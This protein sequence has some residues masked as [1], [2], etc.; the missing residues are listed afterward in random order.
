LRFTQKSQFS[1]LTSLQVK[2]IVIQRPR[3]EVCL[4][5]PEKNS[6]LSH[7]RG[8]EAMF[9]IAA[10][11]DKLRILPEQFDRSPADV[12]IEQIELKYANK[13]LPEVGLCISF[14]DFVHIG[15]PYIYPAEGACHQVVKFRLVVFRPFAGEIITGKILSSSRE[16]VR[17]TLGFFDDILIPHFLLQQPSLYKAATNTWVWNY[18]SEDENSTFSMDRGEEVRFKVRTIS[19]VTVTNT[20][21]ERRTSVQSETRSPRLVTSAAAGTAGAAGA[22]GGAGTVGGGAGQDS[23]PEQLT[24][25]RSSSIAEAESKGGEPAA[26]QIVAS[27]QEDGLGLV[28][29]WR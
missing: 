28:S 20:V 21:K 27:V 22:A 26:M 5:G 19:F 29:W 7:L 17:V 23:A 14:Y 18:D 13:V 4:V 16:G 1:P 11:E 9:V 3:R 25:R 24:R 15:D 2:L 6:Y 12:L 10:V 8:V